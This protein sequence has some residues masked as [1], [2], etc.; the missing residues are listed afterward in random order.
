LDELAEIEHELS[1]LQVTREVQSD[2]PPKSDREKEL[3]KLKADAEKRRAAEA[4][5]EK[6]YDDRAD[7]SKDEYEKIGERLD[8]MRPGW[9]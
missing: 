7:R 3:E 1:I 6:E 5:I 9:R 2:P 4:A 8:R